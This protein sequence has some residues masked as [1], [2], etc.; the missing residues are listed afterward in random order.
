MTGLETVVI[1]LL[2]SI[3]HANSNLSFCPLLCYFLLPDIII[4]Q[5]DLGS[6]SNAI[7]VT[8]T[9]TGYSQASVSMCLGGT[10]I[11]QKGHY[12]DYF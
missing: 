5:N 6:S 1:Q 4:S 2:N 3:G 10:D 11:A 7:C 9:A 12:V 8:V